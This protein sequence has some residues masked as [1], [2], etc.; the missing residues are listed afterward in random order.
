MP[1]TDNLLAKQLREIQDSE[2][3]G[4][5]VA[6]FR[7]MRTESL[8]RLLAY[9]QKYLGAIEQVLAEREKE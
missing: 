9:H 8:K 4:K 7:D 2:R 1:E 5:M 6:R 3:E